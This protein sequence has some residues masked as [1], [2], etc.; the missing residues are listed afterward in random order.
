M[1]TLT[2]EFAV[3]TLQRETGLR[4]MVETRT[5]HTNQR[6]GG[7]IMFHMTTGAVRLAGGTL[8]RAPVETGVCL[9]SA[10]NFRVT[11]QAF[12]SSAA[13]PEIVTARAS[14]DALQLLVRAR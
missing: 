11:L 6:E 4:Q 5:V 13:G 9:H 3:F 2:G 14:R 1:A 10:L 12:E 8:V 7:S